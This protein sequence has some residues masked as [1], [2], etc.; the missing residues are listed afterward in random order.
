MKTKQI[1]YIFIC[2]FLLAFFNATAIFKR[3]K[4]NKSEN[5][6]IQKALIGQYLFF[7]TRLSKNGMKSCATCH[8]PEY[9]F[10]DGYRRTINIDAEL[11][12]HN[13]PSILNLQN[14]ESLN[15]A[16][17]LIKTAKQQILGPLFKTHPIE[18]GMDINN[19]SKLKEISVDENYQKLLKAENIK[20]LNWEL[21]IKYLSDYVEQINSR[22]SRFDKFLKH[23]IKLTN[24]EIA[25]K[26]LFYSNELNCSS[27][28]GGIDFN[29]P[30]N[31]ETFA[32][33]GLYNI[34]KNNEYANNDNGL[35]ETTKNKSD[36]G[37]F[38]IP[39]L[40]NVSVTAPYFHDGSINSIEEV[41]NIFSNG[42]QNISENQY[43][44]NGILH[45]NNQ[46]KP[47]KITEK[48]TKQLVGFLNTLTDTSY[49]STSFF[50]SPF[51]IF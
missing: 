3:A 29:Q 40:R 15:W 50:V 20:A 39:S 42:G 28:H 38:R 7:D 12:Q 30:E 25:G 44:G 4:V 10:T 14:Y 23:K 36:I 22:N 11:L 37:K 19:D 48:E 46:I 21:A 43:A 47:F 51:K 41:I 32:N 1:V 5:R 24:D 17:P 33:I 35:Y 6:N 49:L 13:T 26:N 16:S 9:A 2:L 34:G 18:L 8:A 27:C 45:P 31:N